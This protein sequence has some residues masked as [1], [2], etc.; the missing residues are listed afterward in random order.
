M[1]RN[2]DREPRSNNKRAPKQNDTRRVGKK[3]APPI[4][5]NVTWV[6]YKD[7]NL[8]RKFTS[9]RGKIRSRR[10]SG[11]S[12]QQ[13]SAVAIA[14]KTA[15][16]LALLP[17]V[18]RNITERSPRPPRR[19]APEGAKYETEGEDTEVEADVDTAVEV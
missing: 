2:N 5:G 11:L 9:E 15:R 3:K 7:V 14:V 16:E 17:Y 10:V 18:N 13:Q 6:D 8:L 1:A 19:D 12:V 4:P